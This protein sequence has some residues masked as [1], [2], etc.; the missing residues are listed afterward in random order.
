MRG[1]PIGLRF[2]KDYVLRCRVVSHMQCL[3][4]LGEGHRWFAAHEQSKVL[5]GGSGKQ[6]VGGNETNDFEDSCNGSGAHDVEG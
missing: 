2:A 5:L 1:G 4:H 6:K 3:T